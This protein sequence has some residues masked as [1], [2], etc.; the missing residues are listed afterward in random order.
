MPFAGASGV[1]CSP[2]TG[3][4]FATPAPL[5]G[6]FRVVVTPSRERERESDMSESQPVRES[7][8]DGGSVQ[9]GR[10]ACKSLPAPSRSQAGFCSGAGLG[11]DAIAAELARFNGQHEASRHR[12]M[13]GRDQLPEGGKPGLASHGLTFPRS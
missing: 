4:G 6:G 5:A 2:E 9:I 13:P 3:K 8:A 11:C 7:F 10:T 12:V 1:C